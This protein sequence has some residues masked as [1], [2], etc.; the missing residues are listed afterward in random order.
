MSISIWT[1]KLAYRRWAIGAALATAPL[2]VCAVIWGGW[3]VPQRQRVQ[4]FETIKAILA[5]RPQL[6]RLIVEQRELLREWDQTAWTVQDAGN[7][8]PGIERLADRNFVKLEAL[9]GGGMK[10]GSANAKSG[11]RNVSLGS[12]VAG[13]RTMTLE[14]KAGGPFSRLAYWMSELE[15]QSGLQIDE[16]T[17]KGSEGPREPHELN[18]KMTAFLRE[19]PS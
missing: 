12:S 4:E 10:S 19:T 3:V 9:H 1:K 11:S 5:M 2:I 14:A 18:I 15:Q 17:I 13:H 6:D 7:V 8:L 16:W